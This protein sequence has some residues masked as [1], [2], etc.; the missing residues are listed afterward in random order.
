M[1]SST[2]GPTTGVHRAA[3][4]PGPVLA[5]AAGSVSTSR[6]RAASLTT[7]PT[8]GTRT[9]GPTRARARTSG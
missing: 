1:F 7:T 9:T 4:D 2:D 8:R 6:A 5:N 3:G